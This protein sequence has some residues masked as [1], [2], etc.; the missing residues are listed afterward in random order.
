MRI[1][2]GALG[3]AL[4]LI[5]CLYVYVPWMACIFAMGS[6]LS[7]TSCFPLKSKWL[8]GGL[9]SLAAILMFTMF[10][11]FFHGIAIAHEAN[12][13]YELDHAHRYFAFLFGG[14]V[15]MLA[16]SEFSCWMKGRERSSGSLIS[17]KFRNGVRR[18]HRVGLSD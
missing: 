2:M 4:F 3:V 14:F 9:G 13:W 8:L 7:F 16:M 6:A 1:L 5:A 18:I 15:M 11:W 12:Q 17:E 10:A